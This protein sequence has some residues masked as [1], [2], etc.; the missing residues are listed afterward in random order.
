MTIVFVRPDVPIWQ[1]TLIVWLTPLAGFLSL[2]FLGAR[3]RLDARTVRS[4]I[5]ILA[6]LLVGSFMAVCFIPSA[7]PFFQGFAVLV[8]A[9]LISNMLYYIVARV[10]LI[11][12]RPTPVPDHSHRTDWPTV[13]V[14]LAVRN[15][16]VEVVRQTI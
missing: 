11:F 4:Y 13:T 15:E 1:R 16:P 9:V 12:Y 2:G 5:A 6:L 10:R 14:L 7:W 8:T 3:H